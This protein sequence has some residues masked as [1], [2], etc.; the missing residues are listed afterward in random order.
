MQIQS[1]SFNYQNPLFY[2]TAQSPLPMPQSNLLNQ[3]SYHSLGQSEPE[4][5]LLSSIL[6]RV[7][8]YAFNLISQL[9]GNKNT[10]GF[11][12]A[13]APYENLGILTSPSLAQSSPLW[14]MG[15]DLLNPL[16]PFLGIDKLARSTV[17][18]AKN[19]FSGGFLNIAANV[20]GAI[21][22]IF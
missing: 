12:S 4:M 22:G 10:P 1:P 2:G 15:G 14:G 21:A 16:T 13:V 7:L 3:Q 20:G 17:D 18:S 19:I 8:D 9:S 11:S 5:N 6:F